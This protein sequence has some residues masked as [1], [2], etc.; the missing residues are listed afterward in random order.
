MQSQTQLLR[1]ITFLKY[2]LKHV[3]SN[4]TVMQDKLDQIEKYL[5]QNSFNKPAM[6]VDNVDFS[7]CPLPIDNI[8]DLQTFEDKISG[9]QSYKSRLVS[10][11]N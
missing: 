8:Y 6:E 2:E 7:D 4:Q 5:E 9:D 11:S 1:N 10:F 3:L